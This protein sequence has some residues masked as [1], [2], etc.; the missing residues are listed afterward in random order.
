MESPVRLAPPACV[1]LS[2][3]WLVPRDCACWPPGPGRETR[4]RPEAAGALAVDTVAANYALPNELSWSAIARDIVDTQSNQRLRKQ[5]MPRV[6][7]SLSGPHTER[8]RVCVSIRHTYPIHCKERSVC[9]RQ[10]GRDRKE[11]KRKRVC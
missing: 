5:G 7:S 6:V 3:A 10:R 1:L 8:E 4:T 9:K 11:R 2:R